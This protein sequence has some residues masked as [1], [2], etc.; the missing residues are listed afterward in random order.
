MYQGARIAPM[1]EFATQ[2]R[3]EGSQATFG[4]D[5]YVV[6]NKHF[7]AIVGAGA[8]PSGTAIL[9]P[10]RRYNA[11]GFVAIPGVTGLFATIGEM[12]LDGG[13]PGRH[14]WITTAG[15]MYYS[16][17]FVWTGSVSF[18]KD[19]PGGTPSQSEFV[20]VQYGER[21]HFWVGGSFSTGRVAYQT[22]ALTP[23]DVRF[24]SYGP[25]V[26]FAKWVASNVGLTLRYDYQDQ[27]NAFRRHG[28][29]GTVFF[30]L[31]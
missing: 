25:G 5:S 28:L 29:A 24:L 8:S 6:I 3:P 22:I 4:V 1:V 27:V 10:S 23:I 21:K 12:R 30:E 11:T 9:W 13:E 19:Y 31:P 7:Y 2:T 15:A 20:G 16:G 26:F 14:D 17:R 18:N